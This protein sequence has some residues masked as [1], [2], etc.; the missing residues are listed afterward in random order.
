MEFN[1]PKF[2]IL[3]LWKYTHEHFFFPPEGPAFTENI[4][5]IKKCHVGVVK[6]FYIPPVLALISVAAG[7]SLPLSMRSSKSEFSGACLDVFVS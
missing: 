7:G 4:L 6:H 5:V 3:S 2:S 1:R